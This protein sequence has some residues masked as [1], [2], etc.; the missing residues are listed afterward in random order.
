LASNTQIYKYKGTCKW[1]KVYRPDEKYDSY[2]IVLYL[3]KQS[4]KQYLK[5]GHQGEVKEDEDGQ[6]VTLRRK[7]EVPTK[8][9]PWILGPPEVVNIDRE[10]FTELIGNGSI[11]EVTVST[12]ESRGGMGTRLESVRVLEHVRYERDAQVDA[13]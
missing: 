6:F 11:V 1:A 13:D 9:G 5:N 12:Y 4:L 2:S 10:E 8:K 7:K 3:D